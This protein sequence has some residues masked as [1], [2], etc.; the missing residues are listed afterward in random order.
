MK[1]NGDERTWVKRTRRAR[2]HL[3]PDFAWP[4]RPWTGR[5]NVKMNGASSQISDYCFLNEMVD[6]RWIRYCRSNGLDP[7]TAQAPMF[8]FTD[9]RHGETHQLRDGNCVILCNSLPY[10]NASDR[11]LIPYEKFLMNGW[12][13]NIMTEGLA[14]VLQQWPTQ[15]RTLNC[16]KEPDVLLDSES[17]PVEP[18]K[19][20]QRP[21]RQYNVNS[22]LSDLSGNGMSIPDLTVVMYTCMLSAISDQWAVDPDFGFDFATSEKGVHL[23]VPEEDVCGKAFLIELEKSDDMVYDDSLDSCDGDGEEDEGAASD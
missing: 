18:P 7:A 15:H 11:T 13:D 20:K 14:K 12:E 2:A 5:P 23:V 4:F 21:G 22:V 16:K 10:H 17:K 8:L 6:L 1:N 3:G 19:K 9:L